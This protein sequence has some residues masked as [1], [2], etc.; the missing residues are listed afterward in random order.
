MYILQTLK[1][2]KSNFQCEFY[3][4]FLTLLSVVVK[5]YFSLKRFNFSCIISGYRLAG[6]VIWKDNWSLP[7]YRDIICLI[8]K[9]TWYVSAEIICSWTGH[10]TYQVIQ[11]GVDVLMN[12]AITTAWLVLQTVLWQTVLWREHIRQPTQTWTVF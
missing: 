12:E 8:S 3:L 11:T 2:W 5:H 4:S 10:V 9:H 7:L 6:R 1:T